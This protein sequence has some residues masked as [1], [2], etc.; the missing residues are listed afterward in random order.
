MKT[1][2]WWIYSE[3]ES[4]GWWTALGRKDFPSSASEFG[5]LEHV[6][7]Q[8]HF[9]G[10]SHFPPHALW[11]GKGMWKAWEEP[12]SYRPERTGR[13]GTGRDRIGWDGKAVI[14]W[15]GWPQRRGR[16]I[17]LCSA[18]EQ[19]RADEADFPIVIHHRWLL[20]EDGAGLSASDKEES[21]G[22]TTARAA[23]IATPGT[24]EGWMCQKHLGCLLNKLIPVS[25]A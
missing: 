9:L 23:K 10:S 3:N 1:T 22:S 17:F 19:T 24:R 15:E 20:G 25:H 8:T 16:M 2:C 21:Q 5:I 6:V 11:W 13:D 12:G 7:S 14:T 18:G 4:N